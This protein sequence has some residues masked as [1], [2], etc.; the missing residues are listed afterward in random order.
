MARISVV[1]EFSAAGTILPVGTTFSTSIGT[2]SFLDARTLLE[3][4]AVAAGGLLDATIQISPD[5]SAWS[6]LRTLDQISAVGNV[7]EPVEQHNLS[8]F[9][10]LKYVVT[11]NT[12]TLK[13]T[14]EAKEGE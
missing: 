14:L 9:M 13:A 2:E 4:S 8:R 12:V 6:D 1:N 7:V 10:R 11:V 5:A 3:V